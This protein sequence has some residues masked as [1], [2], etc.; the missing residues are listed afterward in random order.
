MDDWK[1][2]LIPTLTAILGGAGVKFF[3]WLTARS[4]TAAKIQAAQ[5]QAELQRDE[6]TIESALKLMTKQ[7][8]ELNRLGARVEQLEAD[9]D[10][11]RSVIIKQ[12]ATI[13]ELQTTVN[14]LRYENEMVNAKLQQL[15]TELECLRDDGK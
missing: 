2:L 4:D 1:A 14:H 7:E 11:Q 8:A 3:E 13:A 10:R 9:N 6:F 15:Q 5:A 12:D